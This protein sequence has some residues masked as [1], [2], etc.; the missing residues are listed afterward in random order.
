MRAWAILL[1]I[2]ALGLASELQAATLVER[3]LDSLTWRRPLPQGNDL[4]SAA[5]GNGRYV[6]VGR[7]GAM[8]TSIDGVH[9]AVRNE[10]QFQDLLKVTYAITAYG[11]TSTNGLDWTRVTLPGTGFALN[12]IVYGNDRF[13]IGGSDY[14][15]TS[16]DGLNWTNS[17]GNG[18]AAETAAGAGVFVRLQGTFGSRYNRVYCQNIQRS[19]DGLSWTQVFHYNNYLF[20]VAY[21]GPVRCHGQ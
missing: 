8:L 14:S 17:L 10:E 1:L 13:A 4:Y 18:F 15:A 19:T 6:I 2:S 21:V 16:P 11:Y 7:R 5:Y 9:W 3:A 20:G 12:S